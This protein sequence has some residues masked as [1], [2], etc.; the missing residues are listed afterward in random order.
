MQVQSITGVH[1]PRVRCPNCAEGAPPPDLPPL[2]ARIV[3][4]HGRTKRM[5]SVRAIAAGTDWK[6]KASGD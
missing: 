2:P 3:E 6:S 4:Y 1:R 5:K